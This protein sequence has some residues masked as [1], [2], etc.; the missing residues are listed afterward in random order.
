MTNFLLPIGLLRLL[1]PQALLLHHPL[2]VSLE[3]LLAELEISERFDQR[4]FLA[5]G[6][7]GAS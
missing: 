5:H 3:V 4:I 7:G 1:E 2:H 6:A